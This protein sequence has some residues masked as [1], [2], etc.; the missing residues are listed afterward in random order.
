M[1]L[2]EKYLE[3]V[4]K[5]RGIYVLEA[6]MDITDE[7][8]MEFLDA[9]GVMKEQGQVDGP[10]M[11]VPNGTS[12]QYESEFHFERAMQVLRSK[13]RVRRRIWSTK[14]RYL[15]LNLYGVVS[16]YQDGKVSSYSMNTNDMEATD[17]TLYEG[18]SEE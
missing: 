13:G 5:I 4:L 12:F 14:D 11:V 10:L 9:W 3:K 7:E 15:F 17:W 6:G 2:I 1:E 16:K 18:E 8:L